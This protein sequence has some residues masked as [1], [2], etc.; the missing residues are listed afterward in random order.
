MTK[1]EL[2]DTYFGFYDQLNEP[3]RSEAKENWDYEFCSETKVPTSANEAIYCGFDFQDTRHYW[4]NIIYKYF[5]KENTVKENKPNIM[6]REKQEAHF[7][8]FV[9]KQRE[10]LLRKGNDYSA[11]ENRLSNFWLAG[12]ICQLSPEQNC[13]SLIATKVAR[14]GVLLGGKTPNNES[15]QDSVLDLANYA[16]LLDMIISEKQQSGLENMI[17]QVP[18]EPDKYVKIVEV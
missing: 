17:I 7:E 16:V 11:N 4:V 14:L 8:A 18:V 5:K 12:A 15:I 13:L 2:R 10:V 6:T 9:Q 1:E 3:E